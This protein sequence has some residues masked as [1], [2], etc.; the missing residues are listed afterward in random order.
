MSRI[1]A[2][3][4]VWVIDWVA[5]ALT[6]FT[7]D[8]PSPSVRTPS[9]MT[10]MIT[11]TSLETTRAT[12]VSI[13]L[14]THDVEMSAVAPAKASGAKTAATMMSSLRIIIAPHTTI[15]APSTMRARTS[16]TAGLPA[17]VMAVAARIRVPIW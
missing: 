14:R 3:M 17:A 16:T 11:K 5:E 10:K 6:P 7:L 12:I 1:S 2:P 9:P 15:T 4:M 8:S 13:H